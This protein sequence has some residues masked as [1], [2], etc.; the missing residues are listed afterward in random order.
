[1]KQKITYT[2]FT[3]VC[4][5]LSIGCTNNSASNDC[6]CLKES[7]KCLCNSAH[8][9]NNTTTL[10]PITNSSSLGIDV[11]HHNGDIDW[12]LLRSKQ[13]LDFVYIKATEGA[14]HVDKNYFKNVEGANAAGYSIGSYH[15]FRMTSSAHDQFKNFH[16]AIVEAG[17]QS[18]IPM[19]DVE[20]TDGHPISQLQD[21]LNVFISLIK[22]EFGVFPMIYGT[23]KSYNSYCGG[24]FNNFHLYIGR[25]GNKPPIIKGKGHYTIWQYS[26]KGRLPGI[27]KP[28]DIAKF[29]PKYSINDITLPN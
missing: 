25:Y 14:T 23:N 5:I 18:L 29:H 19:V 3:I 28:V 24:N 7:G 15:F 20:T 10:D 8:K 9:P 16:N 17:K 11:S 26:E 4:T 22:K 6:A 21:S 2:L 13:N 27:P 12:N 1:M